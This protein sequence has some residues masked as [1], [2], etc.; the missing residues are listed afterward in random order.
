MTGIHVSST[1]HVSVFHDIF[2]GTVVTIPSDDSGGTKKYRVTK[3][4][5]VNLHVEDEDGKP[6]V[7]AR[8][9]VKYSEDQTFAEAP[10]EPLPVVYLGTVVKFA[11]RDATRFPGE[12]VVIQKLRDGRAKFAKLGGDGDRYVTGT[13]RGIELV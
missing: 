10:K 8:R 11:G 9:G 7:I 3:A 1:G 13:L 12:Y 5:P 2:R 6:W 4:N